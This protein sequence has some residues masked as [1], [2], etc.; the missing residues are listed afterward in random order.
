M[1]LFLL[2]ALAMIAFAANSVLNRLALAQGA[3]DPAGFALVRLLTGGVA[4]W[5]MVLMRRGRLETSGVV[6]VVA[7]AIY[8][9]GFSFAYISLDTGVGA[10]ILFGGVQV[11]MFVGAVALREPVPL[12]RWVGATAAFSGLVYLLWPNGAVRAPIALSGAALMGAAAVG[13]GVYSLLGRGVANPLAVTAGNFVAAIPL[14][15]IVAAA[16]HA[17]A[18]YS[19]MGVVLAGLSGIVTSG[20][21]YALWYAVLPK[22]SASV[23]AISMLSVPIIASLGGVLLVGETVSV[24]L[25]VATVVVLG[26]IGIS[27]LA[28]TRR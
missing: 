24:R 3:I 2:I 17:S 15:V 26:G 4:L 19:T 11:T 22:I 28:K 20:M 16:S 10:L 14:A 1:R 21:G 8:M 5:G 18:S 27:L 23:A 25:I 13:W 6:G 9:L 7:L 12:L